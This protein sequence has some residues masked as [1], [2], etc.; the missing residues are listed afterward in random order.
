MRASA[1]RDDRRR[2]RGRPVRR[3]VRRGAGGRRRGVAC[4]RTSGGVRFSLRDR[5]APSCSPR[6]CPA[7][8]RSPTRSAAATAR[9]PRCGCRC[10][11]TGARPTGYDTA[12]V[13]ELRDEVAADEVRA[14]L[15]DVGDSL[16]LALPGLVEILVE[17]G[18]SPAAAH[19]GRR[20]S[21][22]RSPPARASSRSRCSPTGP[23]E[24]RAARTWRVT[25]ALPA[26]GVG[27][28]AGPRRTPRWCTPRRPP[29]TRSTSPRCSSRPSRSTRPAGTSR[30]VRS[31]DAVLDHAADVYARLARTVARRRRRPARA[32]PHRPR[33]RTRRRRAAPAPGR[34]ARRAPAARPPP[35][36]PDRRVPARRWRV[37]VSGSVQPAALAALGRRVAGLVALPAGRETQARALGVDVRPLADLV[38]ELPAA[39]P[40]EWPELYEAL[41]SLAQDGPQPA[42]RSASLP[43]PLVDGRVVR[44][45]RGTVRARG[46]ARRRR[47]AARPGGLG[48]AHRRPRGRAPVAR[49]ASARSPQT[50]SAAASPEVRRAALDRAG[51]RRA[52]GRD[53]SSRSRRAGRP[54]PRRRAAPGPAC[55][56]S[57]PPT[58]SRRPPTACPAGLARGRPA[59]RARDGTRLLGRGRPLGRRRARRGR[60]APRPRGRHG[61][62]RARRPGLARRRRR[63]RRAAGAVARRLGGLPRAPRRRARR[64]RVRGAGGRGRRPRRRRPTAA[65]RDVLARL[66]GDPGLRRA[67]A[68]AGA[69]RSPVGVGAVVHGVVVARARRP[70]PGRAV[71]VGAE[72]RRPRASPPRAPSPASTSTCSVRSAGV[73][74]GRARRARVVAACCRAGRR[75]SARSWRVDVAAAVW[76]WAAPDEPPEHLPALVGPGR[77]EVVAAADVAVADATDVVA[78]HGRR[79]DGAGHR[80]RARA[81]GLRPAPRL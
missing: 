10:P 28:R 78:A 76:R 80:R 46:G 23:V 37:A 54:T 7:R 68:R 53:A 21:A 58:A 13:L 81:R 22:G 38:E 51:R 30:P 40:G 44:G 72:P 55:S 16:L 4:C 25:W 12:V 77:I 62:R 63:P 48:R 26:A 43:V 65:G 2:A 61:R 1:K 69:R 42:R 75:R 9:C 64:R 18:D 29:T 11:R 73:G 15:R 49:A 32:R 59:R 24:E 70:R 74:A 31:T 45:A 33:R 50:R 57:R 52:D 27:R 39:E 47:D 14:L 5:R 34:R 3:G 6:R 67:L 19:R 35:A 20:A 60:R 66:A 71:R 36:D 79:R 8:R 17:D 56:S 41:A